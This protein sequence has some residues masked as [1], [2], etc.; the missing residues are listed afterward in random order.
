M[1]FNARKQKPPMDFTARAQNFA[2]PLPTFMSSRPTTSIP[3]PAGAGRDPYFNLYNGNNVGH[4]LGG[5]H[6]SSSA[7]NQNL[8]KGQR[9]RSRKSQ[10]N[11]AQWPVGGGQVLGGGQL[12]VQQLPIQH[13]KLSKGQRQ[14]LRKNQQNNA[15][16]GRSRANTNV[17]I[18]KQFTQ[19]GRKRSTPQR[20]M[21][22]GSNYTPFAHQSQVYGE[23]VPSTVDDDKAEDQ[24]GVAETYADYKPAKLTFGAPHPDP[25]VETTSL[26]SIEPNDITYELSIPQ[27]VI[28]NGYLSALQLES[29]LY[30]SQAHEKMLPDGTCAGFLIGMNKLKQ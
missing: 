30:A 17:P 3:K 8:S 20:K 16:A 12:T 19:Q 29:I 9:R 7:S 11:N 1:D 24:L 22:S 5:S 25:V 6:A 21:A 27:R 14:R 13:Q 2:Y 28:E 4:I 23:T 26:S 15:P 18:R 10:Q